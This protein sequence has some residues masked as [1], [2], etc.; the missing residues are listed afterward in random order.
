MSE[1]MN[2]SRYILLQT[3]EEL[4]KDVLKCWLACANKMLPNGVISTIQTTDDTG[5]LRSVALIHREMKDKQQYM[6]P[7]SRDLID[8]EVQPLV[9]RF[10]AKHP[11]LDFEIEVS[12]AQTDQLGAKRDI[13]VDQKKYEG[14]CTAWA[15]KQHDDWVKERLD[16]GWSYGPT[17]SIK[18]KTHPLLRQWY[19]LPEQFKKVDTDQPQSLLDLLNDQGYAVISK[20]ELDGI[21]KLLKGGI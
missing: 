6:I 7:L 1:P 10:A 20:D 5:L 21:M 13:E 19:E 15:K 17:M 3:A 4:P 12:S 11:D 16:G 18:N 2:I 9:D 14:L 8:R